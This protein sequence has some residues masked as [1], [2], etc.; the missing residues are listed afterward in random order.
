MRKLS[1][2][3]T[4]TVYAASCV[5]RQEGVER[6]SIVPSSGPKPRVLC[7]GVAPALPLAL[8]RRQ[9]ASAECTDNVGS[10]HVSAGVSDSG[11][12]APFTRALQRM[13]PSETQVLVAAG[14]VVGVG[15]GV[16]AVMFRWLIQWFTQLFF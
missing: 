2:P 9:T 12:S 7:R 13:G 5:R 8:A 16:G 14:L 1:E 15:A 4:T 6:G 11:A 10:M 3:G